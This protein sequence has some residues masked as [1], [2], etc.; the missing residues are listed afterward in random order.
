MGGERFIVP[1]HLLKVAI[2]DGLMTET[3]DTDTRFGCF[4]AFVDAKGEV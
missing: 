1:G 4:F 2:R 3:S